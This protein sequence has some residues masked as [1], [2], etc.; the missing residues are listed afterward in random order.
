M[1]DQDS[2]RKVLADRLG[3]LNRALATLEHL[4]GRFDLSVHPL[5]GEAVVDNIRADAGASPNVDQLRQY[6]S[7]VRQEVEEVNRLLAIALRTGLSVDLGIE[8]GKV[9]MPVP[10]VRL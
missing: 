2:A 4:G 6:A 8:S 1:S 7:R 5:S 9:T 3:H 10:S